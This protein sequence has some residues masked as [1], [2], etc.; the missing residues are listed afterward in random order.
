[1]GAPRV[2]GDERTYRHTRPA[3]F[4]CYVSQSRQARQQELP[5]GIN[6]S[7]GWYPDLVLAGRAVPLCAK[8][9][10][11]IV[12]LQNREYE[13]RTDTEQQHTIE[14][15]QGT[16]HLPVRL[17]HDPRSASRGHRIDGVEHRSL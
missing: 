7:V 17:E 5:H 1:M 4:P 6:D 2:P 16:H 3:M 8:Q 11:L 13:G 14:G 15:L 10:M 9:Q 12:Q